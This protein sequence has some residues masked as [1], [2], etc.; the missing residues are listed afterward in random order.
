MIL[1][2]LIHYILSC[3]IVCFLSAFVSHFLW[4]FSGQI[5]ILCTYTHWTLNV[6][7]LSLN[8]YLLVLVKINNKTQIEDIAKLG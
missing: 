8:A 4:Y 1:D 2:I 3:K 7:T 6:H 5:V